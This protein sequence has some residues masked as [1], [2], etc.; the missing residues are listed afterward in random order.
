MP[1]RH[2]SAAALGGSIVDIAAADPKTVAP[3]ACNDVVV[4]V[5]ASSSSSC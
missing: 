2:S 5:G 1:T 3:V 4:V